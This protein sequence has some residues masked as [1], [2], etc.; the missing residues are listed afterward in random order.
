MKCQLLLKSK[1]DFLGLISH[2]ANNLFDIFF[3]AQKGNWVCSKPSSSQQ[4]NHNQLITDKLEVQFVFKLV[5]GKT[6]K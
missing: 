5:S 4:W 2:V 6:I 3:I 1:L